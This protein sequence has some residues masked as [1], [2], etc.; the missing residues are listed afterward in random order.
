M[1]AVSTSAFYDR[2]TRSIAALRTRAEGLQG[3]LARGERLT[4]SSQDPV[5]AARLRA[6]SRADTL[7]AVDAEAANRASADLQLADDALSGFTNAIG[8]VRELATQAATGTLNPG[9]RAA[10]GQELAQLNA[11]L[12]S[13]ANARDSAGHALFGGETTGPAYTLDAAGNA[14]Y[15]GTASAG[16]LDLG[17]GQ[18]VARGV[19]G[20]E[21]LNFTASGAATD[22]FVT[23]KGLADALQGGAADPAGFARTALTALDTG[24]A[25]ATTAQ[26]VVGGRLNFID[27]ATTRA[28]Q[29]GEARDLEQATVGGT[30][31]AATVTRLQQTMTVLEASQASF[32]RL[33]GLSLFDLIR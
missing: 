16:A 11:G 19:T 30:D 8:R 13:L 33:S 24:L 2:S 21:F 27:L 20:P 10:I 7:A 28:V 25:A 12:L 4:R 17:D 6:L 15:A 14:A 23:I 29:T 26:T 5:A 3:N 32:A 9:Q 18:S 31:I 1:N 22:L